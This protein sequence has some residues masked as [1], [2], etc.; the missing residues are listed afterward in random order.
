[1]VRVLRCIDANK[2]VAFHIYSFPEEWCTRLPIKGHGKNMPEQ[3]TREELK[4]LGI[5]VQ[6][7]L[8]LCSQRRDPDPAKDRF[9][10][11]A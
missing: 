3:D 5:T 2:G 9:P 7:V 8:Q 6:S 10:T 1:M 11:P 4:F